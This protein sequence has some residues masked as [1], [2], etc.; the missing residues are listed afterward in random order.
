MN[1]NYATQII[2][3]KVGKDCYLEFLP[4][5]LIPYKSSRYYQKTTF[6]VDDSATLVYSETI[7]PGR[8]AMGELFDYDIC[9]LRTLCYNDKHEIKFHDNSILEPKYQ[10]MNTLGMFGNKTVLSTMFVVTKK[11]NIEELYKTINQIFKDN[12]EVVGGASILPNDSGLSVKI[13]S[14]SSEDNKTTVYNIS[15][16]IRRQF[17]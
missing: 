1:S 14:N 11:E 7:V 13:L 3:L 8:V 9:Y 4:E 2:N 5:Q 15:Q 6:T 17:F 10:T 16:I 12:D